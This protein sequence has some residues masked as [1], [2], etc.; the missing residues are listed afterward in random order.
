MDQGNDDFLHALVELG[1]WHPVK[2]KVLITSHPVMALEIPLRSFHIAQIRL[3]E[4]LVDID[5]AAYVQYRLGNFTIPEEHMSVIVEAVP[6]RANGLLLYAELSMD[7][8]VEP[9]ADVYE[10]LKA[11]SADLNDMY[12]KLLRQHAKRS[13]V[14]DEIKFFILQ[15]VTHATRPLRLLEIAE[16]VKATLVPTEHRSLKETKELVR[17]ACSP[18]LEVLQDETVSVVHHCQ[19]FD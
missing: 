10:V 17:A 1:Q 7:A 2:I 6:G 19:G 11:L 16:I 8:F 12:N 5:I 18:L 14:P 3:V 4:R 9:G 13:N 15:F